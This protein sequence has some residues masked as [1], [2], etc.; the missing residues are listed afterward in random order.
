[1][2]IYYL[3][4]QAKTEASATAS[5]VATFNILSLGAIGC[6]EVRVQEVYSISSEYYLQ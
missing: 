4:M 3:F 1:M 2:Q 5:P 6:Y